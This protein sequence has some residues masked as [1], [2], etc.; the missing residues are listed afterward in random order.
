M[1]QALKYFKKAV[2]YKGDSNSDKINIAGTHLNICVI[3]SHMSNHKTGLAH[4]YMAL[5]ILE[6]CNVKHSDMAYLS[7]LVLTHYNIGVEYEK[8]G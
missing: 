5:E 6:S 7:S 2:L 3:Y 4:A 1:T 8:L